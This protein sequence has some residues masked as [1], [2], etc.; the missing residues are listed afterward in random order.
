M[1]NKNT[2]EA[3]TIAIYP[4]SNDDGGYCYDIHASEDLEAIANGER[5]AEDGGQCTGNIQDALD[6]ATEQA[7]KLLK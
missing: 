6:M 3:L 2:I 1:A 7:K 5:D 4:T